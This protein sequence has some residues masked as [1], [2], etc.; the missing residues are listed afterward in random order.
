MGWRIAAPTC[1]PLPRE[2]TFFRES[3]TSGEAFVALDRL[4]DT[5]RSGPL[6]LRPAEIASL[7][8]EQLRTVTADGLKSRVRP[9]VMP[10]DFW[11][12]LVSRS[13]N[14]SAAIGS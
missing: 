12:G 2:R 3:L 10:T 1:A 7:V 14:K 13:G 6:Y 9:L 5:A 11:A 4:L 8:T